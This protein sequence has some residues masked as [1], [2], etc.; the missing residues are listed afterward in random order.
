MHSTANTGHYFLIKGSGFLLGRAPKLWFCL[1]L[2]FIVF[3]F[4]FFILTYSKEEK[5]ASPIPNTAFL[6][7]FCCPTNSISKQ[8][9]KQTL[10]YFPH[11]SVVILAVAL[12]CHGVNVQSLSC[13]VLLAAHLPMLIAARY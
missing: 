9:L 8:Q 12:T 3:L 1:S 13:L 10:Q 11:N 7:C 4:Y 2:S 5:Q 6:L